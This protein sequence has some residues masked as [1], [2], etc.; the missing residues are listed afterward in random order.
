MKRSSYAPDL[1]PKEICL[2]V[3]QYHE[4]HFTRVYHEHIPRHRISE[5][6]LKYLLPA[7]V[8]KFEN[9]EPLTIVRSFLNKRGKDPSAYPFRWEATYPEPG[10]LRKYC[11]ADTCAW[12]DQVVSPSNFWTTAMES[13][14]R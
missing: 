6:A 2:V 1:T 12:V 10:V 7:L 9:S 11:G 8:M 5:D 13:R 3:R 14:N 4:G